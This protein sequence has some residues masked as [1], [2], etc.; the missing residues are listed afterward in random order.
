MARE[1]SIKL[2]GQQLLIKNLGK[3][4]TRVKEEVL[5]T[6]ES[7]FQQ[8]ATDSKGI[9]SQHNVSGDLVNGI[10]TYKKDDK[11][12]YASL[13]K[14]AAFAEFGIRDLVKPTREF[15]NI[16]RTFIGIKN[17]DTGLTAKEN[18]YR[19][20]AAKGIDKT[21]WYPIYRKLIGDPIKKGRSGFEPI[22]EARGYFFV[23]YTQAKRRLEIRLK[24]IIKK[25]LR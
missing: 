12:Y 1:V 3:L 11:I 23:P 14:H 16:A 24:T 20:A 18:I 5:N 25:V 19:W 15:G 13:S 7:E 22:N 2:V 8:A 21:F 4:P 10:T 9:A 6:I 17:N